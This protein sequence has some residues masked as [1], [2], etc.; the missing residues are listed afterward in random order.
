[1]KTNW[2]VFG[3]AC[4]TLLVSGSVLAQRELS[5]VTKTLLGQQEVMITGQTEDAVPETRTIKTDANGH[6]ITTSSAS[7]P[8]GAAS[9]THGA[10]THT[11][12][13]ITGTA[14]NVPSTARAD[15]VSITIC[16][17]TA[18][19]TISCEFDGAAAVLATGMELEELDCI[20][21]N[22]AG[23]VNASCISDG[24]TVDLRIMECP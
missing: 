12:Q 17:S 19:E 3:V 11:Q 1:M 14:A 15:R 4:A 21:V 13:S 8:S 20:K 9:G 10:C 22:L 18:S 2:K 6:L 16:A 23:T 5:L 24:T 7:T